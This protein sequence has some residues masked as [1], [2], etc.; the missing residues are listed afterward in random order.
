M[1]AW[2]NRGLLAFVMFAGSW[3]DCS[4]AIVV[5]DSESDFTM[6]LDP[7][8]VSTNFMGFESLS[9]ASYTSPTYDEDGLQI[10]Q[11]VGDNDIVTTQFDPEGDRGWYPNG[12][13]SGYSRITRID[14]EDFSSLSLFRSSGST[15]SAIRLIF[16]LWDDGIKVLDGN[17]A[18]D[19]FS[20]DNP[21]FI[22]FTGGGFDTLLI[23]DGLGMSTA[24]NSGTTNTL[25]IDA[26]QA[27][28][29]AE[30][31]HVPE[32]STLTVFLSGL[33]GLVSYGWVRNS[34]RAKR[35]TTS[36]L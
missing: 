14:N 32:P 13:D 4:G 26:V 20:D 15:N 3:I 25:A 8:F 29:P 28:G 33:L 9:S 6:D 30:T 19:N 35:N 21:G 12:G 7:S 11:V 24:L 36:L 5:H 27:F 31:A 16:E 22:G 1:T 18:H 17:L 2:I 34:N 10:E 23:R